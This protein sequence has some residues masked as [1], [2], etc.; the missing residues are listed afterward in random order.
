MGSDMSDYLFCITR[1]ENP[2]CIE[3]C[4]SKDDPREDSFAAKLRRREMGQFT[5]E[6]TLPVVDGS[7]SEAALRKVLRRQTHPKVKHGFTCSAM[8]ARGQAVRFTTLRPPAGRRK[9]LSLW[10]RFLRAA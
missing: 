5:L 3:I 4:M 9:K 2:D 7:L 8:D 1:N 10:Q 6:W